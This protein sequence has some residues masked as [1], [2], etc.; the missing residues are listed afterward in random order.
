V[1][2]TGLTDVDYERSQ[3]E[4]Q[5]YEQDR[6]ADHFV[7]R[8]LGSSNGSGDSG[9]GQSRQNNT[10]SNDGGTGS[11]QQATKQDNPTELYMALVF[12][13][14]S[15]EAL[16][17]DESWGLEGGD[18]LSLAFFEGLGDNGDSFCDLYSFEMT[19]SGG[20]WAFLNVLGF[21]VSL[22]F[23]QFPK[24]STRNKIADSFT[25][26][27]TSIGASGKLLFGGNA[28][29]VVGAPNWKGISLGGGVGGGGGAGFLDTFYYPI[30][31]V[32]VNPQSSSM[33]LFD[34]LGFFGD[35][36]STGMYSGMGE[37]VRR[38]KEKMK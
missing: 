29:F 19:E 31:G 15:G 21:N 38:Y 23:Q 17:F 36:M 27:F 28:S 33:T 12:E 9:G 26:K 35:G 14:S 7:D 10:G 34:A 3:G 4:K 24:N 30:N 37:D 5:Q 25:G 22:Y 2:P 11:S 32:S 13:V 6:Q 20:N 8:G 18:G 1:D 16:A